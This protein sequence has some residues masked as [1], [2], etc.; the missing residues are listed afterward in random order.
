MNQQPSVG[1][2]PSDSQWRKEHED[3]L[4]TL[5]SGSEKKNWK[6]IAAEMNDKFTAVSLQP[7][8]CYRQWKVL[9][10]ER[11]PWNDRDRYMLLVAHQRYKNRWAEVALMIHKQSRNLVKNKFYTLFRKVRN[12]IICFDFH[13]SSSLDLLETMYIV[14]LI[15][16]YCKVMISKQMKEK[17]YAY[18]LVQKTDKA[19]LAKYKIMLKE[20]YEGKAEMEE[21]F[22][23]CEALYNSNP[24]KE[25]AYAEIDLKEIEERIVLPK[26]NNFDSYEVMGLEEKYRFWNAVFVNKE[27]RPRSAFDKPAKFA[28]SPTESSLTAPATTTSSAM[29]DDEGLGFSQFVSAKSK[30]LPLVS[31]ILPC[32]ESGQQFRRGKNEAAR[33]A[34]AFTSSEPMSPRSLLLTNSQA[35][36][37]GRRGEREFGTVHY[38]AITQCG[39]LETP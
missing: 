5:A 1:Q 24:Y 12:R 14:F 30:A 36:G 31:V 39:R 32:S 13:M 10:G 3:H 17:N 26:P 25:S 35:T 8:D 28:A 37:V 6:T 38:A 21:L 20:Q 33:S 23:E 2:R 18:K 27:V 16:E 9:T 11:E 7:R 19:K 29:R 4:L 15:E 22:K 34:L